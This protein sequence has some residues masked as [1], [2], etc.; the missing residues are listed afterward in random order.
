MAIGCKKE[1]RAPVTV[2]LPPNEYLNTWCAGFEDIAPEFQRG[3]RKHWMFST[4]TPL[5]Q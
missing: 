5:A 2:S 1:A 4:A 3:S